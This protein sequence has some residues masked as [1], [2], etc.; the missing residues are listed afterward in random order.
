MSDALGT[1]GTTDPWI[2]SR[3]IVSV[4]L[5]KQFRCFVARLSMVLFRFLHLSF[6]WSGVLVS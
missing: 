1:F 2:D 3:G 4:I 6:D 5:I